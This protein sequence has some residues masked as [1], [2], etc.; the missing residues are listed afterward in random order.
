MKVF[1]HHGEKLLGK[2][3]PPAAGLAPEYNRLK[4]G[5]DTD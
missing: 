1:S 3:S 4:I 5:L 2:S